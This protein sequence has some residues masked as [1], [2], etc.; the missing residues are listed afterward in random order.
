MQT[1]ISS[2]WIIIVIG[3]SIERELVKFRLKT[4]PISLFPPLENVA[5]GKK[6][7][8]PS[9]SIPSPYIPIK[10]KRLFSTRLKSKFERY[11]RKV[12]IFASPRFAWL[13]IRNRIA[14]DRSRPFFPLLLSSPP[15]PSFTVSPPPPPPAPP[16]LEIRATKMGASRREDI[17]SSVIGTPCA[18]SHREML[19]PSHSTTRSFFMYR[20][21][22]DLH[23]PYRSNQR[24]FNGMVV[25]RNK[26]FFFF[27]FFSFENYPALE[28]RYVAFHDYFDR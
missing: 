21:Q 28:I 6:K 23:L 16:P 3:I 14:T 17:E 15:S 19:S 1:F 5:L 2:C 7:L 27:F 18:S 9:L 24:E 11:K 10:K 26:F 13:A 25:S 8:Y 20:A 4:F 12:W 22:P